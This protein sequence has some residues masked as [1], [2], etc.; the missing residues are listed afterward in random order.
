MILY[1]LHIIYPK[2]HPSPHPLIS[3][4]YPCNLPRKE[5]KKQK[6]KKQTNK[7]TKQNNISP[8]KMH[9]T[10]LSKHFY[11]QMFIAMSHRSGLSSL[12]SII[13]L[14]LD[15]PLDS[16]WIFYVSCV[17]EFLQL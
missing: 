2:Y 14:I 6:R 9:Y 11:L 5:N 15:L 3:A 10:L 1:E 4:L 13:P 8:W 16:A 12:A 17:T 7:Q